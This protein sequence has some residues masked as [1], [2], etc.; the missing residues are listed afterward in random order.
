MSSG[1]G[2]LSFRYCNTGNEVTFFV[3][4]RET[5][6]VKNLLTS[7]PSLIQSAASQAFGL[8]CG[9]LR[10]ESDATPIFK[11]FFATFSAYF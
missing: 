9:I 11:S 3:Y 2:D 1:I 8:S 10:I 4:G 5:V 6:E 7:T